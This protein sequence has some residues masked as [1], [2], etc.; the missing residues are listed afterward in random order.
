MTYAT[1]F[2]S[3]G[4][5]ENLRS[6]FNDLRTFV[7]AALTGSTC[8]TDPGLQIGTSSKKAVR[9]NNAFS[10][11]DDGVTVTKAAAETAFTATTHD[12]ADG[13]KRIFVLSIVT[14]GTIT[15]TPGTAVLAASTATAPATPTGEAKI[16]EVQI[17]AS[18]AIFNATTDDLDAAHLT[19]TYTDWDYTSRNAL[20][21]AG[22][23]LTEN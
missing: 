17:A 15:I 14:A 3:G 20:S 1:M 11:T 4:N 12:V 22:F 13:Y 5:S 21:A 7:L 16:G 2:K 19:V 23:Q 6:T 8:L 18:G 9:N 10:F